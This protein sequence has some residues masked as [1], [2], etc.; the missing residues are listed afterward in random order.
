MHILGR[1]FLKFN[2]LKRKNKFNRISRN[3]IISNPSNKTRVYSSMIQLLGKYRINTYNRENNELLFPNIIEM[4]QNNADE[5]DSGQET[6]CLRRSARIQHKSKGKDVEDKPEIVKKAKRTR[7]LKEAKTK[8]VTDTCENPITSTKKI[9]RRNTIC[10]KSQKCTPIPTQDSQSTSGLCEIPVEQ[11]QPPGETQDIPSIYF[12][13]NLYNYLDN[14][15]VSQIDPSHETES[16][17]NTLNAEDDFGFLMSTIGS[18]QEK[19]IIDQL[20]ESLQDETNMNE[21]TGETETNIF[22]Q[23]F[24]FPTSKNLVED[25]IPNDREW[26]TGKIIIFIKLTL[27]TQHY[28]CSFCKFVSSF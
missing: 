21:E 28:D 22:D 2:N 27:K 9:K 14:S 8:N 5:M 6:P 12:D 19:G 16:G 1:R 4:K 10:S 23:T 24:F 15:S 20:T 3:Q 18:P 25:N 7:S 17:M 11:K 13:K 26:S